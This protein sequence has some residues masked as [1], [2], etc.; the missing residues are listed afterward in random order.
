[1]YPWGLQLPKYQ[2]CI[3]HEDSK[4]AKFIETTQDCFLHQH[5]IE[6]TRRRF[7]LILYFNSVGV[8]PQLGWV[9]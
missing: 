5:I 2:A 6:P 8:R 4:E 9:Y 3:T 7:F 1:M